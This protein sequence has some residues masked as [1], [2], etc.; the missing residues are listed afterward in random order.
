MER[1]IAENTVHQPLHLP[2]KLRMAS[3]T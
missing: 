2:G 3:L 1:V